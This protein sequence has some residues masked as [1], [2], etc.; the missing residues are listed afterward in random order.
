MTSPPGASK[1]FYLLLQPKHPDIDEE[2]AFEVMS[3]CDAATVQKIFDT[4]RG[5]VPA[6]MQTP[7][8]AAAP[9]A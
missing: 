7:K 6:P 1:L 5:V 9:A 4:T 8:N 2:R 3:C